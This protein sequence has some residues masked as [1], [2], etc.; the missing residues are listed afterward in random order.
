MKSEPILTKRR[1]VILFLLVISI[2]VLIL[3]TRL[4]TVLER[5]AVSKL[6]QLGATEVSLKFAD[7]GLESTQL[8]ELS[9]VLER[10]ARRYT[11]TSHDIGVSYVLSEL[12]T[13]S[14]ESI[15]VPEISVRVEALPGRSVSGQS[16]ILP[17]AEWL[18][19][20]PFNDFNLE[21][22]KLELPGED[23]RTRVIEANGQLSVESASANARVDIQTNDYGSQRLELNL[24]PTGQS[25]L[26]LSDIRTPSMPVTY[27]ELTSGAWTSTDSQL[28]AS[29]GVDID[30]QKLQQQLQRWGIEVIPQGASGR[31]TA[32]GPLL[33]GLNNNSSWQPKG[34]LA[35]QIPNL[36]KQ[37]NQ[38]KKLMMDVPLE[39]SLNNEQLQWRI[40]EGGQLLLKKIQFD[41]TRIKSISAK[42]LAGVGCGVQIDSRD[43]SCEPFAF[44]LTIPSIKNKK[45]KIAIS[46][47]RLEFTSL[48]GRNNTWAA[49]L[50]VDIPD[51]IIDIGNGKSAKQ[52]KLDK[53]HGSIDASNQKLN[54]KLALVT[55]GGATVHIN[56]THEIKNEVGQA[57]YRLAPV[58]MQ[59]V[60]FAEAY[61]D[62]PAKLLLNAGTIGGIGELSWR[63]GEL[64]PSPQ[65]TLTM[66]NVGGAHDEITFAGLSGTFD[67]KG[68]DD[69]YIKS[70]QGLSLA[71]L[72]IGA[73]IT[74]ISLQAEVILPKGG[75]P[76]LTV[77]DLTM[78][79]LGGKMTGKQVELDFA[80]E[81]NPFILQ[82]SG[83]DVEQL[84]KLEQ[85]QGLF[86]SGIIDGELPLLL[87]SE[88]LSMQDGKLAAR[89]PGGKLIYSADE[90]VQS[91][92]KS[93]AG[94]QLLVTAMEDF[95]YKVLEADADYTPD[96]LLKLKVRL[97]GSNPEL[98][99]GRPVHLNV[100]VED[101]ILEL[102]RSLRLASD[103]SEKIGEQIQKRQL[104]Q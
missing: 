21:Q 99:G 79:V 23:G 73:P 90:G 53:V 1:L 55:R 4:P 2:A 62:W 84:L 67:I 34:T 104:G 61:S 77:A 39:M 35:L 74:D 57:R 14:F 43:W 47:G 3:L 17:P 49:S 59:R 63:S 64:L 75:K 9:F 85:K 71:N 48:A 41:K 25:R 89:K 93:N 18:A 96:G 72:N 78:N 58:D 29:V 80:R 7:I 51:W 94:V 32:Q 26:V 92:A 37:G 82:V 31:L 98:E 56:A 15:N 6:E 86:G 66:Q 87:T 38:L 22:L 16:S 65:A 10:N 69:L 30:V 11:I 12:F 88:G 52:L 28:Q 103:I 5:V 50:G 19:S 45:N 60:V 95:N 8:G 102:L 20:I 68:L 13:G 42:L 83:V 33:V 46:T 24:T 36:E 100:D 40:G 76:K 101:N 54:A 44:G 97:K 27:T 91:M 81:Q 70:R